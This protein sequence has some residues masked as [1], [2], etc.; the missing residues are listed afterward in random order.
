M[1]TNLKI[2]KEL[3]PFTRWY[4][5]K[6]AKI[7]RIE[8]VDH[9]RLKE[10]AWLLIRCFSANKKSDLYS[11]ALKNNVITEKEWLTDLLQIFE[12]TNAIATAN[13]GKLF[14][15]K[16]AGRDIPVPQDFKMLRGEM[17][18]S[19]AV[20]DNSITAK[21]LRCP[22]PGINPDTEISSELAAANFPHSPAYHGRI[23]YADKKEKTY[24]LITFGEFIRG[25]SDGW[26]YVQAA[27][28]EK[29]HEGLFKFI[30]AC[31]EALAGLHLQFAAVNKKTFQPEPVNPAFIKKW[32]SGLKATKERTKSVIKKFPACKIKA[33]DI[34]SAFNKIGKK[35]SAHDSGML[36]RQHG[37]FHLGQVIRNEKGK[38]YLLDF[39]GE[40]IVQLK[41]RLKKFLPLKDVAGFTRSL[42]YASVAALLMRKTDDEKGLKHWHEKARDIFLAKYFKQIKGAAFAPKA[43]GTLLAA[44]ELEK[45]LYELQYEIQNRPD[46]VRIP[47]EGIKEIVK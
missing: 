30:E 9:A 6:D 36:I 29:K 37:D 41:D 11:L 38:V 28:A 33:H 40:P 35:L 43:P 27:L 10:T 22:Q 32:L 16:P 4:R 20:L 18:N 1:K 21:F 23:S 19:I 45:A 42:H 17:S 24:E 46:W 44:M 13:G 14:L 34:D 2:I 26:S 5:R 3:L 31:A 15:D 8:I 7:S 12:S 25:A 39:E 47:L